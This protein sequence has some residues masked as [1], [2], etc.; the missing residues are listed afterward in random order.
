MV[1]TSPQPHSIDK[2]EYYGSKAVKIFED[3]QKIFMVAIFAFDAGK[4]VANHCNRDNDRSPVRHRAARIE[5]VA[6][7]EMIAQATV[8]AGV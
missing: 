7:H 1:S 8:V 6:Q 4:S 3:G 2:I 5:M